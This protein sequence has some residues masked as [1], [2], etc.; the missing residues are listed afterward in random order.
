MS[1]AA[2]VLSDDDRALIDAALA[3]RAHAIAPCS[4]YQVGAA[5]RCED[6]TIVEGVNVENWVLPLTI[7]AEHGAVCAGAARGYRRY[8][9]VAV[10]TSSS[11]PA[12]PCG[13][14][15]QVLHTHGVT[16][17]L[18]AN[19]QGERRVHALA[20]LL[21]HAFVFERDAPPGDG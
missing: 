4:G 7:C 9:T 14:C 10:A 1:D 19:P 17:V 8:T 21:P 2:P 3:V 6:G 15:R 16:R 13:S 11:P 5:L 20:D 18:L 12:A